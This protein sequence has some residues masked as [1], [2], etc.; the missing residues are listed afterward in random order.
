M[1][2]A[3]EHLG[4]EEDQPQELSN[5]AARAD[6]IRS[7][8]R[9]ITELEAERKSI[10][11]EISSIKQKKVKGDLGMKIADFNVALRLYGLEAEDRDEF[12]DSLR[13]TFGALGVGAQLDWI[14]ELAHSKPS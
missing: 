2:A 6:T 10:G 14:D 13:E 5:S 9:E 4:G 11:K 12:F 7:A 1:D 8:C 3:R